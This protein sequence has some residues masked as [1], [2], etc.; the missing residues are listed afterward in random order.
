MW[1]TPPG[2][3]QDETL[4]AGEFCT[5]LREV[6]ETLSEG[7]QMKSAEYYLGKV[8]IHSPADPDGL[9]FHR[10]VGAALNDR[11]SEIM[12]QSYHEARFNSRGPYFVDPTGSAEQTLADQFNLEAEDVENAGFPPFSGGIA[13]DIGKLLAR[14]PEHRG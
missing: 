10:A 5:W 12:R 3:R 13:Q 14:C 2:M 9:W 8:L 4:D 7:Q 1:Q 6:R 11:N